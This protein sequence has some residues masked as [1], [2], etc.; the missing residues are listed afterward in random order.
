MSGVGAA[1]RIMP[2]NAIEPCS[3][4]QRTGLD[5]ERNGPKWA[6]FDLIP[7]TSL[8]LALVDQEALAAAKVVAAI[9]E[10][11]PSDAKLRALATAS[12]AAKAAARA[13]I[14][15][16]NA[17]RVGQEESMAP[18]KDHHELVEEDAMSNRAA[19]GEL[20]IQHHE[21]TTNDQSRRQKSSNNV[22]RNSRSAAPVYKRR[23]LSAIVA[24]EASRA[25]ANA[26]ANRAI[27]LA[28]LKH[29]ARKPRSNAPKRSGTTPE[30]AQARHQAQPSPNSQLPAMADESRAGNH[31]PPCSSQ[32]TKSQ[33]APPPTSSLPSNL[34]QASF[35]SN[36][37]RWNVFEIP[38]PSHHETIPSFAPTAT[39]AQDL[40]LAAEESPRGNHASKCMR[41]PREAERLSCL[42][43]S[44]NTLDDARL[45]KSSPIAA[46]RTHTLSDVLKY[47]PPKHLPQEVRNSLRSHVLSS[48][49]TQNIQF[50]DRFVK[51][52]GLQSRHSPDTDLG[53]LE[54]V[55]PVV[56]AVEKG[57][58]GLG[59]MA[60]N[61][62]AVDMDA[63]SDKA[64]SCT[65]TCVPGR[66]F[67]EL[68]KCCGA[69]KINHRDGS[70][71]SREANCSMITDEQG[72]MR[73]SNA[74]MV[75]SCS[76]PLQAAAYAGVSSR[77]HS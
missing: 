27:S 19:E 56:E 71:H 53:R 15:L 57:S 30:A 24:S 51:S 14:A 55:L 73:V 42:E 17:Y 39:T 33:D 60:S 44:C 76:V 12:A 65:P 3:K 47:H 45:K 72:K 37:Q 16:D 32:S 46:L 50:D 13:K 25:L 61:Y 62:K 26:A 38:H 31:E 2:N 22:P 68:G 49:S 9:A 10:K 35:E 69:M 23:T 77:G 41:N 70:L 21:S 11:E 1:A 7:Q 20:M 8:E 43:A 64:T 66:K 29:Q 40:N 4:K 18:D 59:F 34:S 5:P 75:S 52:S 58:R 6:G 28:T 74:G 36:S 54:I 48:L 63:Y 67:S